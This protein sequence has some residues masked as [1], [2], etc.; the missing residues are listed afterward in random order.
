MAQAFLK[1][2]R[3]VAQGL[4]LLQR[5]LILP[6]LVQRYGDADFVGAK[7]DTVT[8]RIPSILRGREYEWR[9]RNLPIEIDELEEF[10]VDVSLDTHIYSAV[11]ITDEELTL[12][13]PLGASRLRVRRCGR[14]RSSSRRRSLRRWRRRTSAIR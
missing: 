2:E 3:I 8:I 10:S 9:T 12:S 6:R 1:A 7:N 14:L 5:E 13:S 11:Q 4:G